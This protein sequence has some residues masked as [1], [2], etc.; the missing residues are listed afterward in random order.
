MPMKQCVESVT[1]PSASPLGWSGIVANSA[2]GRGKGRDRVDRLVHAFHEERLATRV[3]WTLESRTELVAA[4]ESDPSCH[5]LVAVGGDGTVAGLINE[6]P[7]VPMTVLPAGT[8]N[9]FARHF[10]LRP[11]PK[12]IARIVATG[13]TVPTDVGLADGRRFSLMAGFGFDAE[14][15][16]R[17][18]LARGSSGVLK[19]THRAAYVEPVLRSSFTYPFPP[20]TIE[21]L[22]HGQ[23]ETLIGTTAFLFNLP[24]YALGLPFAPKATAHDG[25]LDLIV[26]RTPGPFHALRYLWLVL[27]GIHF[28]K[29]GIYYRRIRQARIST[30][31]DVP[32]Q[33]DGDPGGVV[34]DNHPWIIGILPEAVNVLVPEAYVASLNAVRVASTGAIG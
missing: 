31:A 22:D 33:L 7:T 19:P 17:H 12:L 1:F 5:G 32:V 30:T 27:R 29:P 23:E 13:R 25:W 21:I 6:Q 2:S 11:D 28:Q 8:E 34:A 18:H 4:A 26:F 15:V 10:G 3:A 20:L 9:L 24:R 16:T 14:V